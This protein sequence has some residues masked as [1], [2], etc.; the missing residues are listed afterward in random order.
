RKLAASAIGHP[1]KNS[2]APWRERP[3][4]RGGSL[5]GRADWGLRTSDLPRSAGVRILERIIKTG[6]GVCP[7]GSPS[8]P[9]FQ[10][11]LWDKCFYMV[12]PRGVEPLTFSLRTR[13]S[14][15]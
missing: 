4:V 1:D 7:L 13:R 2:A 10:G 11:F 6:I 3:G 14:T 8:V 15:N 5:P 12:E 9:A